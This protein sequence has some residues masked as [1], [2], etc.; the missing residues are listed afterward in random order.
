[1]DN[2]IY[3]V[4]LIINLNSFQVNLILFYVLLLVFEIIIF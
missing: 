3:Y 2:I 4:G 1:M